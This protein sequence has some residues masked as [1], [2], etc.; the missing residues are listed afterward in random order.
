MGQ[1]RGETIGGGGG[2]NFF[3]KALP[4][5]GKSEMAP[6]HTLRYHP[7]YAVTQVMLRHNSPHDRRHAVIRSTR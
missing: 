6:L 1:I 4:P 7:D 3:S 2:R 5:Q